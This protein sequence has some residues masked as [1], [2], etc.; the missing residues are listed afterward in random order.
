[1][2]PTHFFEIISVF[3]SKGE[4]VL[5]FTKA[6]VDQLNPNEDGMRLAMAMGQDPRLGAEASPLVRGGLPA[7]VMPLI[8]G[9]VYP[10]FDAA[11]I[12]YAR[13]SMP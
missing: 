10:H 13:R 1:L 2:T 12:G 7:E 4:H 3:N 11:K 8:W 9:G 5:V 6:N